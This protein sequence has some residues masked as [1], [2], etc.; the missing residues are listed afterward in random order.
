M[1]TQRFVFVVNYVSLNVV[2]KLYM[3]DGCVFFFFSSR[4]RHTR[5]SRDW[6][7][8]VCSSDLVRQKPGPRMAPG[9]S[10][11]SVVCVAGGAANA[12]AL[13]PTRVGIWRVGVGV[14]DLIGT[15]AQ[16]RGT[17]QAV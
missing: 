7:S 17:E 15:A 11:V 4:R 12:D 16:R 10:F 14:V 5:C 13:N 6:S 9:R 1:R 2:D 3:C 8:D